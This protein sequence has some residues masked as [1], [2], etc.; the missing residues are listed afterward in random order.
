MVDAWRASFRKNSLISSTFAKPSA[1]VERRKC[2]VVPEDWLTDVR[3]RQHRALLWPAPMAWCDVVEP[4][5]G[6]LHP[7]R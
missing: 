1:N 7:L 3:Q 2:P 6:T 4:R 5:I